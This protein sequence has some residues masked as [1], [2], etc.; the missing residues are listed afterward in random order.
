MA[1]NNYGY[2]KGISIGKHKINNK[3][4][5]YS[6]DLFDIVSKKQKAYHYLFKS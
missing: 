3:E 4:F 1:F 2:R 5:D 6:K